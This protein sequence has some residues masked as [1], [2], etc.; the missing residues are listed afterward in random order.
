MEVATKGDGY[1]FWYYYYILRGNILK[2]IKQAVLWLHAN[3][4]LLEDDVEWLFKT[5]KLG[6]R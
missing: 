3:H 1:M 2:M 5:F 4:V 6:D